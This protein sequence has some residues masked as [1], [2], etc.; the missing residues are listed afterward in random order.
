MM[1]ARRAKTLKGND[2][3]K[4]NDHEKNACRSEKRISATFSGGNAQQSEID[5]GEAAI[6]EKF[7]Y[8]RQRRRCTEIR[9]AA[10][11]GANELDN[12]ER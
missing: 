1:T 4:T 2:Y 10:S 11:K 7:R 3:V 8:C 9:R 5:G 12:D 6:N